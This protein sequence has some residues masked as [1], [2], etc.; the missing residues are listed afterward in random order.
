MPYPCNAP[1]L[2]RVLRTIKASV[3]C[4]TSLPS[5]TI[6]LLL[7]THILLP[8]F[9][10]ENNT[11]QCTRSASPGSGSPI[12]EFDLR[13]RVGNRRFRG[14]CVTHGPRELPRTQRLG[15]RQ[16]REWNRHLA[17][18]VTRSLHSSETQRLSDPD[19]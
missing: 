5:P 18:M 17:C 7:V 13:F 19:F 16:C 11:Y 4:R 12:S 2:S 1:M 9:L 15:H 14:L 6:A 10:L 8:W 3:P